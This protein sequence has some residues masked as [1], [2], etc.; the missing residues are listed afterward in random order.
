MTQPKR[1]RPKNNRIKL[2]R[3]FYEPNQPDPNPSQLDF[4]SGPNEI[5]LK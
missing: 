3:I 4:Q 1:T 2:I 5:D